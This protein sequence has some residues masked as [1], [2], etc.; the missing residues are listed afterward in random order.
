MRR[1]V[2]VGIFILIALLVTLHF[3]QLDADP[4]VMLAQYGQSALTDP[5]L[6]TWHAR[7]ATLFPPDQR[8]EYERFAPL[9][10]TAVSAAA[11]IV[12]EIAGVSRVTANVA[13]V[14][15][16]LGGILFWLL[17]LR[18]YWS[19]SRVT[20]VAL[21]LFSNFILITY[22]KMPYLENGLI[23]LFG[24]TFFVFAR[25]G[26]RA[27]GQFVTGIM[28]A[29]AALCGKLF[30]VLLFVPIA[31]SF[32]YFNRT[33]SLNPIGLT[34]LGGLIG[35][36]LYILI[37]MKGDFNLWW[38]YHLDNTDLLSVSK[39]IT[40]PLGPLGMFLSFGG[41]GGLT[42]FGI[43]SI[44]IA[45][46]GSIVWL[47]TRNLRALTRDD[48]PLLFSFAWL[49]ITMLAFF[50]FE[51][52]PLRYLVVAI[53]PALT[54]SG[55]LIEW[56]RGI[57]RLS[58]KPT[59]LTLPLIFIITLYLTNQ[60]IAYGA[61]LAHTFIG[62]K[63]VLPY[64]LIGSVIMTALMFLIQRSKTIALPPMICRIIIAMICL[65]YI[66]TNGSDL[67][68]ALS[69][70]RYDLKT[71]NRE[72]AETIDPSAVVTG[73]YAPALT[74][75]NNLNGVFNYLGTVRH[76]PSFFANF[77]PTHLLTNSS[78]LTEINKDYHRLGGAFSFSEPILWSYHLNFVSL[79]KT[80]F[81]PTLFER[82][83]LA[84]AQGDADSALMMLD[85]F[86]RAYL[87]NR[88]VETFRVNLY[89]TLYRNSDSAIWLVDRLTEKYP[90]DLY[91]S[92]FA[93]IAYKSARLPEK[94]RLMLER[95]NRINPF[96]R[97][98]LN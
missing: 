10:F 45:I 64:C 84:E 86:E 11:R 68:A 69:Q 78:D 63:S 93:A 92:A 88:L 56:W 94:S 18:K 13:S 53:I 30:G 23:F 14:L 77:H 38:Q 85:A 34:L 70:P 8:I 87:N 32:M 39:Y 25:W 43:G 97:P 57:L 71:L 19:W 26:D 82:A 55:P 72:I 35:L 59:W 54:F 80:N 73:S 76:D 6:Y 91:I 33:K 96:A 9:E 4:P 5:Y 81:R 24:L 79:T 41:E 7:Q 22:A 83:V 46:V 40:N 52:R 20:V 48:A 89:T 37:A 60:I 27:I 95:C 62:F 44:V 58:L 49:T 42:L 31:L 3:L 65:F 90:E 17:G 75:D 61:N 47:S 66:G 15:L 74:I 21:L 98:R 16:C 50:P 51:Y 67:Y 1:A 28:I 36:A 29:A 2:F 12:F